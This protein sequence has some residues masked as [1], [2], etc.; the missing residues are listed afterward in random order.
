MT[1]QRTTSL[2]AFVG[3]GLGVMAVTLAPATF[4]QQPDTSSWVCEY[5]PF[6]D[7]YRAEYEAGTSYVTE[8]AA[9]FG[10]ANGYNEQGAY[11]NLDGT[12]SYASGNYQAQW[13]AED[14]GLDSRYLS[15]TGGSQGTYGYRLAYRELP[16]HRFD[17]TQTVFQ[18]ASAD[19]QRA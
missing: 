5:C 19:D 16:R 9:H 11:L 14:L 17:T 2:P 18:Q 4:A 6:A 1:L 10:D 13:V 3:R 12:G 8:D 7:A 15:V